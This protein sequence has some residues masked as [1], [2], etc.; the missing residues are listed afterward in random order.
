MPKARGLL[1]LSV[2]SLSLVAGCGGEGYIG[3]D[4]GK[5]QTEV[6]A[7]VYRS[8]RVERPDGSKESVDIIGPHVEVR[9]V[10]EGARA[11]AGTKA[12]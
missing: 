1:L 2:S 7:G 3:Y 8:E 10:T 4:D 5:K 6:R 11:S 9:T 12:P